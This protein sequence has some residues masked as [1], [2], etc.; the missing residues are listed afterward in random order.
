[1]FDSEKIVKHKNMATK[2]K[3]DVDETSITAQE[4]AGHIVGLC[5]RV[6][7]GSFGKRHFNAL[8]EG[9]DP[10]AL[11]SKVHKVDVNDQVERW[12]HH[13]KTLYKI[14]PDFSGL[15]IPERVED[16]SRLIIVP[17]GLTHRKWVDTART[18]HPV[19]TYDH[20]LDEI[21]KKNDRNPR[22]RSYGIWIRDPQEADEEL[23]NK[24][25][26]KVEEILQE[27]NGITL[28]ERLVGGTGHL[29]DEMCHMDN[30]G[31]WTLCSGSCDS[32]SRVPFVRCGGSRGVNVDR[33]SV[34][35]NIPNLR[36]R[37]V[38]SE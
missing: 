31:R 14:N 20:D 35:E 2:E 17:K 24:S 29:F 18:I 3:V 5:K 4:L 21:V 25:A 34:S 9:R 6:K 16:F 23:K 33:C 37:K 12:R 1:M 38:V 27:V 30:D 26:R 28:L 11:D 8:A 19:S 7:E 36:T 22:E 32:E 13:F 10:F 15:Y